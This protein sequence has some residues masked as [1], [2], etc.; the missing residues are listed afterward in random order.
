[1]N[2]IACPKMLEKSPLDGKEKDMFFRAQFKKQ[3]CF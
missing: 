1:M 3:T 2:A